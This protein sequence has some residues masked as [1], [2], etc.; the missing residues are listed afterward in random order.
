M[1]AEH[2]TT[3]KDGTEIA[4]ERTGAGTPLVLVSAAL[5]GRATYRPLAE[6][7]SGH[8]TVLNYDRRGRGGSGDTAPYA[9][10]REIE[11]LGAVIAEAGG[12]ASAYG[13]S[14]GAALVQHAAAYGLPI[15]KIVLHE[16]PFGS[17]TEEERQAERQ[18]AER[19]SA[20]LARGRHG[21]A[22]RTFLEPMGLPP[23]VLDDL[24]RDA[25]M[26]AHAPTLRYDPFEVMSEYSRGGRT[27]AEQAAGVTTAA[28]V[29]AGGA[30]PEWMIEAARRIADALPKGR[31]HILQDQEHVVQPEILAPVLTDFLTG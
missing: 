9:V 10:E 19:I 31:L 5:Q 30:S 6:A 12:T 20:L 7:L 27:P 28:L 22:V 8:F 18:E 14:S 25:A 16:P 17:G 2:R 1:T 24:S 4:F 3:S 13:H 26:R 21:D 23:Q 15:D 29:L 11:D